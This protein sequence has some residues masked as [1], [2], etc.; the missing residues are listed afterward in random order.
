MHRWKHFRIL[1]WCIH[2]INATCKIFCQRWLSLLTVPG[3]SSHQRDRSCASIASKHT[4]GQPW[5]NHIELLHGQTQLACKINL[6]V[7]ADHLTP[8]STV[9]RNLF[10]CGIV[11]TFRWRIANFDTKTD[12]SFHKP[13]VDQILSSHKLYSRKTE[14]IGRGND[15]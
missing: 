14:H 4:W 15:E 8:R 12:A 3:T 9:W 11:F 2:A 13:R 5:G 7:I 6:N 10:D 1:C